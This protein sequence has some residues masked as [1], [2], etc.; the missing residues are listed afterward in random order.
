MKVK[1]ISTA[2]RATLMA[3]LPHWQ[4]VNNNK[5][6]RRVLRFEDF[7]QAWGAMTRIAMEAERID[8]HPEWLNIY[9][10][11]KVTLTTHECDG[12]SKRDIALARFIDS[13]V[14]EITL[15]KE[16]KHA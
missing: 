1:K 6:I 7:N 15:N 9:G 12:L 5:A 14:H 16:K 3:K 2:S 4:L 8:H 11:V 10:K 13:I